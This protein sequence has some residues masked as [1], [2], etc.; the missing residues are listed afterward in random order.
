MIFD[1][2]FGAGSRESD[3]VVCDLRRGPPLSG[4]RFR[5]VATTD[6]SQ[7]DWFQIIFY[8]FFNSLSHG[9]GVAGM[10]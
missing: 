3:S 1:A 5:T 7:K 9:C 2:R 8:L 6:Q 4:V 10:S